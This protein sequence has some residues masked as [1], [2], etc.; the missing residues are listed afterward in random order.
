M[1]FVSDYDGVAMT[2][3]RYAT[4]LVPSLLTAP[5]YFAGEIEFG[6]I[7]QVGSCRW[8]WVCQCTALPNHM[9]EIVEPALLGM[10]HSP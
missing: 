6:V 2:L 1:P 9:F 5:R 3:G 7:A 10:L 8:A 4:I